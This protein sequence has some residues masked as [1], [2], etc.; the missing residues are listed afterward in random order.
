[1]LWEVEEADDVYTTSTITQ[2]KN[3]C[4][5]SCYW[6]DRANQ[7]PIFIFVV[8]VIFTFYLFQNIRFLF[9]LKRQ[10][11]SV[12]KTRKEK[13]WQCVSPALDAFWLSVAPANV[14]QTRVNSVLVVGTI[15]PSF[16]LMT[17][18]RTVTMSPRCIL[19]KRI[20]FYL[21]LLFCLGL[22][23][24]KPFPQKRQMTWVPLWGALRWSQGASNRS[25]SRAAARATA[26]P[27]AIAPPLRGTRRVRRPRRSTG[28]GT[29]L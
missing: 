22:R 12:K 21:I 10:Q 20:P 13:N 16:E 19:L 11:K 14:T 25:R 6:E 5:V 17:L 15:F 7:T 3:T 24:K 2:D 29:L 27:A 4:D 18:A 9:V 1:M 28:T 26:S 8:V 23:R